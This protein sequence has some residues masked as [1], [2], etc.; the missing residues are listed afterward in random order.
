MHNGGVVLM[1]DTWPEDARL[2]V[3]A[4]EDAHAPSLCVV[5][6]VR[7]LTAWLLMLRGVCRRLCAAGFA[8]QRE[9]MGG[10]A[11]HPPSHCDRRIHLRGH[12]GDTRTL[13]SKPRVRRPPP[14]RLTPAHRP[15]GG[16]RKSLSIPAR[17]PVRTDEPKCPDG[18]SSLPPCLSPSPPSVSHWSIGCALLAASSLLIQERKKGRTCLTG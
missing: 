17:T 6:G 5:V 16:S 11:Q 8:S 4:D 3:S 13:S 15:A 2:P 18:A 14:R 10:D 1:V 9:T 7:G 12:P